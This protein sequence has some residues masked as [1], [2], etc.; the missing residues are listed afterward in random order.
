MHSTCLCASVLTLGPLGFVFFFLNILRILEAE[1]GITSK[2]RRADS[3]H[4]SETGALANFHCAPW[5]KLNATGGRSPVPTEKGVGSWASSGILLRA[6][7]TR[8]PTCRI[9]TRSTRSTTSSRSSSPRRNPNQ[10]L[11]S[12][13][14]RPTSPTRSRRTTR[15]TFRVLLP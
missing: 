12:K 10:S 14:T 13:T 2:D 11:A 3:T 4:F 5:F 8:R 9:R 15:P 7:S 6:N 1:H